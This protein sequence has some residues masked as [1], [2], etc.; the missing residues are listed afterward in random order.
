VEGEGYLL[1][2]GGQ[3]MDDEQ[4]AQQ[5]YLDIINRATDYVHIM[6]PYLIPDNELLA[7]LKFAAKR[8]VDVKMI[9]P[10]VPDKKTVFALSRSYYRELLAAGVE[11]W[12]YTPGF[13][14]GKMFVS[15]DR[16]AVVG[17][18]N[19]DYRSLYH[20]FE[21]AALLWRC[22]A[23]AEVKADM[24]RTREQCRRLTVEDCRRD[25]LWRRLLGWVFR[26]LAPLI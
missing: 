6:T 21:C 18:V 13:T 19:L 7:A 3:P 17:S 1:P 26:P 11:V 15:D 14:H 12:E 16:V 2:Y 25:K 9:L 23:V 10:G 24:A 22:G 8:G 4:V 20:H 5:V